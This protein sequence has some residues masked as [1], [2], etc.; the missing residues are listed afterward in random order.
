MMDKTINNL[1]VSCEGNCFQQLLNLRHHSIWSIDLQIPCVLWI[2]SL[3]IWALGGSSSSWRTSLTCIDSFSCLPCAP[4][5]EWARKSIWYSPQTLQSC[6]CLNYAVDP[7]LIRTVICIVDCCTWASCGILFFG[8]CH[9][10][11][12]YFTYLMMKPN[13]D[14]TSTCFLTWQGQ[15]SSLFLYETISANLALALFRLWHGAFQ[16]NIVSGVQ[17]KQTQQCIKVY[18]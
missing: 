4:W 7:S 13:S 8:S 14:I 18:T 1:S 17:N 16:S 9:I 11:P 3:S 15:N 2:F 6:Y 5:Y 10:R 12:N